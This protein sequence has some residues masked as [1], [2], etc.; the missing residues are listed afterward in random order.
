ME[1]LKKEYDDII[2]LRKKIIR[3]LKALE[4]NKIVLR[5]KK[6]KSEN[7]FLFNKELQLH[8][9]LKKKEYESCNHIW[10]IAE[11]ICDGYDFKSHKYFGCIKCGL[12]YSVLKCGLD[13]NLNWLPFSERIMYEYL[14]SLKGVE[15]ERLL[16]KGNRIN[17]LCDLELAQAIYCN[18]KSDYPKIEEAQA[19][20]YFLK[21]I[22]DMRNV[23]ASHERKKDRDKG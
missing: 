9:E 19:I 21:E 16:E 15:R 3:E 1:D 6:L 2:F 13:Y 10:I 23:K 22:N 5:Y 12:D 4:E 14:M 18:I 8:E 17:I 7:N 20:K 11:E